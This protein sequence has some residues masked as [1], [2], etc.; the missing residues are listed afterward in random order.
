LDEFEKQRLEA[1]V[2]HRRHMRT[3]ISGTRSF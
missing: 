2:I 1:L 3:S